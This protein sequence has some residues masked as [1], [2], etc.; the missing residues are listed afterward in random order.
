[1]ADDPRDWQQVRAEA[2]KA[3]LAAATDFGHDL[4][5]AGPA[6]GFA[7]AVLAVVQRVGKPKPRQARK[8]AD[9]R[10]AKLTEAAKGV[11][12]AYQRFLDEGDLDALRDSL[13]ILMEAVDA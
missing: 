9:A 2:I 8:A 12:A 5:V 4:L 3:V 11:L 1:V 10:A 7:D 6:D 13:T